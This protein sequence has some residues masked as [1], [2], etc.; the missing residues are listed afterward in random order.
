MNLRAIAL[1]S[2]VPLAALLVQGAASVS[3]PVEVQAVDTTITIRSTG[4]NLEFEPPEISVK[5]GKRVRIRF[6]NF[7]TLPHNFVIPRTDADIDPLAAAAVDATPHYI[8]VAMKDRMIA[9]SALAL[10]GGNTVEVTFVVPPP[11]EYTYVCLY[12]GHANTMIGTLTSLR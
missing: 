8:P 6:A 12:P 3:S 2:A 1:C 9:Y 5:A 11:G 4:S 7:G 10:P